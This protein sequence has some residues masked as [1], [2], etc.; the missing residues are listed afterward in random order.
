LLGADKGSY[1]HECFLRGLPQLTVLME[2]KYCKG[3]STRGGVKVKVRAVPTI[4]VHEEPDFHFISKMSP[5][6]LYTFAADIYSPKP[7]FDV[8]DGKKDKASV[9]TNTES[10][11]KEAM[12]VDPLPLTNHHHNR[13]SH[14][15]FDSLLVAG[16]S[17]SYCD[18]SDM[19]KGS[20]HN[21][22]LYLGRAHPC[23][24]ETGYIQ[25]ESHYHQNHNHSMNVQTQC[26]VQVIAQASEKL[27]LPPS[28]MEERNTNTLHTSTAAKPP[29]TPNANDVATDNQEEYLLKTPETPT[30]RSNN[31]NQH[32]SSI[33]FD[34]FFNSILKSGDG[35]DVDSILG[36]Y[37]WSTMI[38]TPTSP[39]KNS[40][41]ANEKASNTQTGKF[42][43]FYPFEEQKLYHTPIPIQ[44]RPSPPNQLSQPLKDPQQG[45][46]DMAM[47]MVPL[48]EAYNY[49]MRNSNVFQ[50]YNCVSQERSNR[51]EGQPSTIIAMQGQED[52]I[53][54]SNHH[55]PIFQ[56]FQSSSLFM[57]ISSNQYQ[58][59][60]A[61]LPPC[62]LV[63]VLVPSGKLLGIVLSDNIAGASAGSI[64]STHTPTRVCAI[65]SNS[66]LAGKVQVGDELIKIDGKDVS[67]LRLKQIMS[68]IA[69]RRDFER[70][71]VFKSF[72]SNND[73]QSQEC[74]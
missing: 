7:K 39:T 43:G 12:D 19:W 49:D 51:K 21:R 9:N 34:C 16:S 29:P 31:D 74:I 58:S 41:V 27:V 62:N 18:T 37:D 3:A 30:W 40:N 25:P 56:R 26:Q 17:C 33:G 8:D 59:T 61:T 60:T 22:N 1:Y 6:P 46:N 71:L 55:G 15:N 10:S 28:I 52:E 14:S 44:P 57:P 50:H 66:F 47:T 68:L 23:Q 24:D 36:K 4:R 48:G 38:P 54:L 42:C 2:R 5:L 70:A 65:Q 64:S 11:A 13:H 67:Q 20:N 35:N 73:S 45:N 72:Q 32:D 63:S 69:S 53:S